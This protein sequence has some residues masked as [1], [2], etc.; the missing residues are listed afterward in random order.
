[1]KKFV[2]VFIILIFCILSFAKI[3]FKSNSA[4]D[5]VFWTLQMGDFSEYMNGIISEFEKDNPNIKIKWIDVP[6][7]EGEKRTLASVLSDNPPDLINATPDFSSCYIWI[8]LFLYSLIIRN[9][10]PP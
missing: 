7:S 8:L 2:L 9:Y 10:V 1:M 5:I 3:A 4:Q 6:F